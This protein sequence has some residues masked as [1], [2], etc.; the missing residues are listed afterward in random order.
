MLVKNWMSK[1]VI[2]AD[3]NDSMQDTQHRAIPAAKIQSQVSRK[4]RVAMHGRSQGEQARV[5]F[6]QD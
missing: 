2:T 1:D 3:V 6:K 4:S 5:L